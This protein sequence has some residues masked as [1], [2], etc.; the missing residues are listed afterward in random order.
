MALPL[1]LCFQSFTAGFFLSVLLR[2][3]RC[4]LTAVRS[5]IC[6]RTHLLNTRSLILS[7]YFFQLLNDVDGRFRW[8]LYIR[9][10]FEVTGWVDSWSP[11]L[12]LAIAGDS[13]PTVIRPLVDPRWVHWDRWP[14]FI[15]APYGT[16]WWTTTAVCHVRALRQNSVGELRR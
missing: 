1:S 16:L 15:P 4:P 5:S 3:S 14:L 8:Q 11:V 10:S 9:I 13:P 6:Y 2:Y 12:G 7:C